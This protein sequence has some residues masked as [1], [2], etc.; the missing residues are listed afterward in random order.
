MSHYDTHAAQIAAWAWEN[1]QHLREVIL[2]VS[3]TIQQRF[4]TVPTI[5]ADIREHGDR[6]RY[7][8]GS[9]RA[10][11]RYATDHA[12]DLFADLRSVR[13]IEDP[14]DAAC[15]AVGVLLAVPGLGM[16]KAGFVAQLL[17][18]EVGCLDTH[19]LQR[20]G[21]KPDAFKL[22]STLSEPTRRRKVRQYVETCRKHGGARRLWNE[23]CDHVAGRWPAT[24]SSGADVS[25]AHC[26]ALG[27]A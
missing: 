14:E 18:F 25:G 12:E 10:T 19:N 7:L 15:A 16:V 1:P 6:S 9:K 24:W 11:Y 22:A 3:A 2:F 5:L 17:G 13:D 21:Y 4:E 8:F 20:F 26:R 27:L 23:W